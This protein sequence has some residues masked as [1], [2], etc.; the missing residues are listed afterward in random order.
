MEK[1]IKSGLTQKEAAIEVIEILNKFY[2]SKMMDIAIGFDSEGEIDY[3]F[4]VHN[5]SD[6]MVEVYNTQNGSL[7]DMVDELEKENLT[8]EE[9]AELSECFLPGCWGMN[10]DGE[11]WDEKTQDFFEIEIEFADDK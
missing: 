4:N 7:G 1:T 5:D 11:D 2:T 8:D 6:C 3:W 9:I 10:T